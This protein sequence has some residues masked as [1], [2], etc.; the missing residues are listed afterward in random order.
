MS[1][2]LFRLLL[3]VGLD[4]PELLSFGRNFF[5][6]VVDVVAETDVGHYLPNEALQNAQLFVRV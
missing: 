2:L 5:V 3:L 6:K 4:R 1:S